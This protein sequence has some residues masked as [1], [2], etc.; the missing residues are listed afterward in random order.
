[1]RLA[2]AGLRSRPGA[3]DAALRPRDHRLGGPAA[4]P[5][6]ALL[7]VALALVFAMVGISSPLAI[8][9][10][11]AAMEGATQIV[12]GVLPYGHLPGDVIHGDTYPILSYALYAPVAWVAP[13]ESTFSS[14][15]AALAV[16][17]LAAL[18]TAGML[19]RGAAGARR[20]RPPGAE[21]AGCAS[22]SGGSHPRPCSSSPRR[23]HR[24]RA[25][26]DARARGAALV[27]SR[28]VDGRARG[29]RL[30]QARAVCARTGLA[31][32]AQGS[33]AR[34]VD[35]LT[36]RRVG[37]GNRA[38]T[39]AW[40]PPW[41]RGDG[42]RGLLSARP[43]L[44]SVA[45]GGARDH[46][47]SADRPSLRPCVDRGRRRTP[48]YDHELAG[49]RAR[50]AALSAA[51]LL[52]LELVA[53]YWTFLYLAWIL[54]LISLSL[55]ADGCGATADRPGCTSVGGRDPLHSSQ[56]L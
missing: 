24:R 32:A 23:N 29:R 12:H 51:I 7:L 34:G 13:V 4:S 27:A 48:R 1:M 53:N 26:G 31:G 11:Y 22:R 16:A 49:D 39:R 33:A 28:R 10:A 36:R 41:S 52:A 43:R 21:A 42:A 35:R 46:E 2:R 54:P 30:V 55:V 25:R 38:R 37:G 14:V 8:D 19:F 44:G 17:V 50:I 18:A 47:R 5:R 3:L 20:A 45:L 56:T 6:A 9:V 40:W 15:D